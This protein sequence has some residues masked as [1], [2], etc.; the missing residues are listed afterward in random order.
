[1]SF[2]GRNRHNRTMP[3]QNQFRH[4][5][6]NDQFDPAQV[7]WLKVGDVPAPREFAAL[8]AENIRTVILV[9]GTFVGQDMT[10]LTSRLAHR[11]PQWF[12]LLAD[13]QKSSWDHVLGDDGNYCPEFQSS[14]QTQLA[15]LAIQVQRFVWSSE[16]SHIGRADAAIRLINLLPDCLKNGRVMMWGHSHGGNVLALVTNL[17]TASADRIRRFFASCAVYYRSFRSARTWQHWREARRIILEKTIDPQQLILITFG[18]PVRY[19]WDAGGYYRLAH[20]IHH[21]PAADT[22]PHL[23]VFPPSAEAALKGNQGDLIQQLGIAGTDMIPSLTAW[24]L[25]RAERRLKLLLQPGLR[26][27]D[28]YQRWQQGRRVH[29]DGMNYLVDYQLRDESVVSHHLG[30]AIYTRINQLQQ[31]LVWIDQFLQDPRQL[32]R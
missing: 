32:D 2:R 11:F 4:Q 27:R 26:T 10:G 21:V 7:R 9:H 16:N 19:G 24:R 5:S 13:L 31:H 20:F 8:E 17:L 28:L 15:P 23:A 29:E 3:H 25:R 14:L 22:P 18:T 30:H 1:M 6:Y 12:R